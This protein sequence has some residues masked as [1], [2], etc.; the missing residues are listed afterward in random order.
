MHWFCF[1]YFEDNSDIRCRFMNML[2]NIVAIYAFGHEPSFSDPE[3]EVSGWW[4]TI[5]STG[6]IVIHSPYRQLAVCSQKKTISFVIFPSEN[7]HI[8]SIS[9]LKYLWLLWW[10]VTTGTGDSADSRWWINKRSCEDL[11]PFFRW[12]LMFQHL[13][14]LHK[15]SYP[16]WN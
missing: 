10:G 13:T 8:C 11:L 14:T 5:F 9:Q 7:H 3:T 6:T 2:A 4:I 12:F 16:P 15:Y 1:A